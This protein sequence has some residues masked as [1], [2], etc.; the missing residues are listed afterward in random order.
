MTQTATS[1]RGHGVVVHANPVAEDGASIY[2][3]GKAAVTL[4]I[5]GAYMGECETAE[6]AR[7]KAAE[8]TD[9]IGLVWETRP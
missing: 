5:D 8:V 2:T 7:K 9:D 3:V 1:K 6:S 4:W